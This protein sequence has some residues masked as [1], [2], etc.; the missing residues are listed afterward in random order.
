M[1][2][3]E[4]FKN[5][6]FKLKKQDPGKRS[7]PGRPLQAQDH[8]F[9]TRPWQ[10]ELARKAKHDISGDL[11][12]RIARPGK[13]RRVTSSRARQVNNRGKVQAAASFHYVPALQLIRPRVALGPFQV[14][15]AD[16]KSVV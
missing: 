16:R 7:L 13:A 8:P 15:V 12:W 5:K 11:P 2:P 6:V 9:V 14:H 10:E 4:P 3:L 1:V